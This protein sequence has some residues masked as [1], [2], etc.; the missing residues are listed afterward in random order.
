MKYALLINIT[1]IL[2]TLTT[3]KVTWLTP[4]EHDMGDIQYRQPA[5]HTFEF[6]NDS[7]AELIIDTVRPG[8]GCT[9]PEWSEAPIAPDSTG[10][11]AVAYDARDK[12]YFR[13]LLKVYF[14]GQRKAERLWL[15]GYVIE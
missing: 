8:C 2:I 13:K 7:E 11:I 5:Y 1:L 14:Q 9:I 6:K 4:T 10:R 3:T 15:E 12:G